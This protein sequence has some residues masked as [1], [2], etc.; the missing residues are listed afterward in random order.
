MLSTILLAGL[1]L[2]FSIGR[3]VN[4]PN[5]IISANPQVVA[6]N[7]NNTTPLAVPEITTSGINNFANVPSSFTADQHW[8][9]GSPTAKVKIQEFS[10]FQCPFCHVYF[11]NTFGKIFEDYIKTGKVYYTYYNYPLGIHPQ[12]PLAAEAALCA[13]DQNK[14]W[15]MHDMLFSNQDAWSFLDNNR[16]TFEKLANNIYLNMNDFKNCLD[17]NKYTAL[18]KK[19]QT[20]GDTKG[21]TGT[22]TIFINDKKYVGALPYTDPTKQNFKDAIEAALKQ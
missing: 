17:T 11:E 8:T 22:P 4:P 18:V 13:G 6:N 2:G 12:A 14:Y 7:Q 15:E 5:Q 9:L 21:V 3:F 19:D 1:I 16:E 20:L 10:D